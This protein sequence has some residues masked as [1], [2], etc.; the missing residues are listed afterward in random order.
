MPLNRPLPHAP[1]AV[2]LQTIILTWLPIALGIIVGTLTRLVVFVF[3]G[4]RLPAAVG[5]VVCAALGAAAAALWLGASG[6]W[7][8]R[9][10]LWKVGVTW[11]LLT[12]LFRAAWVGLA[13]GGGWD[14]V[15][16]DYRATEGQPLPF[17]LAVIAAAPLLA[18]WRTRRPGRASA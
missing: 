18:A 14:A 2:P 3:G 5:S 16:G 1:P 11:V 9:R 4:G 6:D 15:V 13:I 17:M 8:G 12:V 7:P 10:H